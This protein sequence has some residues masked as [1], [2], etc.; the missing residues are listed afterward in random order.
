M[1]DA[2]TARR[3]PA[4][5]RVLD[6]GFATELER[7]GADISGALWSARLLLD[8]PGRIEAVH[9]AYYEAGAE[10][11]ITASYQAS[12]GGFAQ[13]GLD[14]AETTR[15]LQLSVELA[16]RARR[17]YLAEHPAPP[18][19]LWVAASVGPFGAAR[20]DGSEYHGDYGVGQRELHDFHRER[21]RVLAATAPDILAC[22]TIP[23]LNEARVLT[24]LLPE[25]TAARAWISFTACD[26]RHTAHG[27]P[28]ADCARLLDAVPQ[29]VAIG[30]NCV[31]PDHVTSLIREIRR[32]TAKPIVVYPN[33]GERWNGAAHEWQGASDDA[34]LA[35]RVPEWIA[36]GAVWIGGCC[37]T[38]PEAIAAVRRAVDALDDAGASRPSGASLEPNG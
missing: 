3:P 34:A 36:A 27:E 21:L 12:Y 13:E 17:A 15:L 6:G 26:D 28:L 16:A 9:R 38:T 31:R 14:A 37:R 8:D 30:V 33:S 11:A 2:S 7:R 32:G 25:V 35:D 18:R 19:A 5:L 29:V 22:E 10:V 4:P 20:H 23:S 24:E 1:S